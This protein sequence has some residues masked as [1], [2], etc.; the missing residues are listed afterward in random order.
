MSRFYKIFLF[1]IFILFFAQTSFAAELKLSPSSGSY[2]VGDKIN[3]KIVLSSSGQSANAVSGTLSFSK[4]VLTMNSI[5]KTGSLVSL[6]AV[7]PSYSN[8]AGTANMEG[9]ILNGYFGSSGTIL[10]LSFRAKAIGDANIK[11][12][13]S[14]VL[15]NDGE[16]TSIITGTGQANFS[17][18]KAVEKVAPA[19]K[20]GPEPAPA[21][22]IVPVVT[23]VVV[24]VLTPVFTDYSKDLK[25]GEFIVV[26]GLADSSVDVNI[27][28]DSVFSSTDKIAHDTVTIKSNDKGAFAYVSDRTTAGI[29][30]ITAQAKNKDGV[31]SDKSLPIKINVLSSE[32]STSLF[33]RITNT[34][35]LIIPITALIILLILLLLWSWYKVLHYRESM[36]KKFTSSQ[37]VVNKSFNILDEDV[38]EEIKI[39][40]KIKALE[41]LT[42]EERTYINQFK[43]DLEGAERTILDEMSHIRKI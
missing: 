19:P 16:G 30:M 32:E 21:T 3:V 13:S 18:D 31:E 1:S 17:I 23:S 25:E 38:K 15:A 11:F 42:I 26:K 4:N 22:P 28:S 12:T 39:F 24:K 8:T 37:A 2:R 10:T 41:P 36:Q 9:V 14:S 5:S 34:F 33:S 43:K 27:I 35:S 29:Y 7:E 6:W 40:K 20:I